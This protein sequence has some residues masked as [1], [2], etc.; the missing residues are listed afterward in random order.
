M[1]TQ[2]LVYLLITALLGTSY[3]YVSTA[4]I[5]PIPL[6]YRIG[7]IDEGFAIT[8]DEA[9]ARMAQAEAVWEEGVGQELFQYDEQSSFTVNFIFDNRQAMADDEAARSA[10]LDAERARN[11]A[12]FAGID[13]LEATYDRLAASY[14]ADVALYESRLETYNR[15]VA[16]YND[17]GGAPES[18]FTELQQEQADLDAAAAALS[19]RADELNGLA[20]QINDLGA[21]G[22]ELI[23]AYNRQVV[24]FNREF[25]YSREFTQGEYRGD[26]INIYKF[27][28]DPELATVLAHELGHALGIEHVADENA[29][30]YYLLTDTSGM[31]RL[32]AADVQA[33]TQACATE[34]TVGHQV[35]QFIRQLISAF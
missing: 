24:A 7:T 31:P 22:N 34:G 25:G 15:T 12:F 23:A 9:V 8:E 2:F 28:T 26:R 4:S 13:E 35:R 32:S 19:A 5:C 33:F 16:R 18:V 29:L 30:M 1:R 3:W 17:Q 11:I 10:A 20:T 14:E 6:T 21:E 27:S